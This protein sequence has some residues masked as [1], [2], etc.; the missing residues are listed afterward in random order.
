MIKTVCYQ[1]WLSL[2]QR[3]EIGKKGAEIDVTLAIFNP[4][5][6]VN[7]DQ[8]DNFTMIYFTSVNENLTQFVKVLFVKLTDMLDSSIFVRF[9]HRQSFALYGSLN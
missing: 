6:Q 7:R 2:A 3:Y 9:F 1:K 4:H 5:D 8:R